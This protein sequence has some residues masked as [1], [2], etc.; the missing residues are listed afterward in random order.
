MVRLVVKTDL[1]EHKAARR[2]DIPNNDPKVG[3]L[4]C[5]VMVDLPGHAGRGS[6]PHAFVQPISP[7]RAPG[8][9]P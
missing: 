1:K 5:P 6:P 2:R 7:A 9:L 4:N 8:A 3:A